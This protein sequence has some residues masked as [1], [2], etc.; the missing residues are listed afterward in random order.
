MKPH[1]QFKPLTVQLIAALIAGGLLPLD[2]KLIDRAA[3]LMDD[4][5]NGVL[6][7]DMTPP[8]GAI[9]PLSDAQ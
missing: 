7:Q 3:V 8:P 9:E 1:R 4:I 2:G 5:V 6:V